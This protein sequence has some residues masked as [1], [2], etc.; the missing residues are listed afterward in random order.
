MNNI[1]INQ[2]TNNTTITQLCDYSDSVVEFNA[3]HAT[4]TI[5]IKRYGN[6]GIE[7]IDPHNFSYSTMSYSYLQAMTKLVELTSD[8][9]QYNQK[10]ERTSFQVLHLAGANESLLQY[11]NNN[12]RNRVLE[13]IFFELMD[14]NT[15][16]LVNNGYVVT[17]TIMNIISNDISALE[18]YLMYCNKINDINH[19][20]S[21]MSNIDTI[22][23][24]VKFQ[25]NARDKK[26]YF[27]KLSNENICNIILSVFSENKLY[28]NMLNKINKDE[29]SFEYMNELIMSLDNN[30]EKVSNEKQLNKEQAINAIIEN[31]ISNF[32]IKKRNIKNIYNEFEFRIEMFLGYLDLYEYTNEQLQAETTID[33]YDINIIKTQKELKMLGNDLYNCVGSYTDLG[34]D[35]AIYRVSKD[36]ISVACVDVRNNAVVEAKGKYNR[37][38]GDELNNIMIQW[39]DMNNYTFSPT[40]KSI[41][42]DIRLP[43]NKSSITVNNT[44][45]IPF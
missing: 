45:E 21:F 31:V 1:F 23:Q 24:V 19:A 15:E 10:L 43:Q 41:N 25:H 18:T 6:A 35:K 16:S 26:D 11:R 2:D 29:Q 28:I 22:Q 5:E 30:I 4:N 42:A 3:I 8:K 20:N 32:N 14:N 33:G 17:K 9:M 38:I 34:N 40:I 7:T 39:M 12:R 44:E 27:N 37:Y 13:T 36:K